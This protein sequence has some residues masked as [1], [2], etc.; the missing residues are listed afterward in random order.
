VDPEADTR[1]A[2]RS[3]LG[4]DFDDGQR[5][6][7]VRISRRLLTPRGRFYGGAGVALASAAIE[8]ATKRRLRWLTAQFVSSAAEGD[9]ID[10]AVDIA[11]EG[12][13]TTQASV[14]G[15][16]DGRVLFNA[17]GSADT[18]PGDVPDGQFVTM[19]EVDP[20]AA[21]PPMQLP[22]PANFVAGHFVTNELLAAGPEHGT[23]VR[24]WA[25]LLDHDARRPAMLGY[26]SDYMPFVVMRAVGVVGA[27]NSVDNTVRVGNP[28]AATSTSPW[29]LIDLAPEVATAG[30]GHGTA[31]LWSED[32]QLLGVASQTTR[33]A[34]FAP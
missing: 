16:V 7:I 21:C 23:S 24:I 14:Q 22:L 1:L 12:R 13:T 28:P 11:A 25:R 29:V 34:G 10:V 27:G 4:L 18:A 33:L 20:P 3:F 8:A 30:Y 32:G 6:G 17:L 9:H 31:R 15:I 26:I 19:P 5:Q 2:D